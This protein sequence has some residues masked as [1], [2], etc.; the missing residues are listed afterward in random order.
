MG[1]EESSEVLTLRVSRPVRSPWLKRAPPPRRRPP[2]PR[3]GPA[4]SAKKRRA[5]GWRRGPPPRW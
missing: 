1:F 3:R 5:H 2:A 4:P